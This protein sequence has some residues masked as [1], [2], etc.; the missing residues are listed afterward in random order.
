MNF[1]YSIVRPVLH[2]LEP[3]IAHDLAI[4]AFKTGLVGRR[5]HP[6]DPILSSKVWNTHFPNP[7]GLAAGFDKNGEVVN[8]MHA[9]GFGFVEVG[10][11]TP[12]PQPGNPR[13]RLYRLD[14]DEAA[15]N[16]YGFNSKGIDQFNGGEESNAVTVMLDGLD[17]NGGGQMSF[18]GALSAHEDDVLR[19][20]QELAL[21]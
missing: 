18:A 5:K 11:I 20:L 4:I 6:D 2:L 21:V 17:T 19:I 3:E 8:A 10:T 16:Q 9:L 12:L 7:I 13:P 14:E 1:L 15:I